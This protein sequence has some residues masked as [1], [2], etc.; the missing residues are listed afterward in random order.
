MI[1]WTISCV[2]LYSIF[3]LAFSSFRACICFSRSS[4]LERSLSKTAREI[5]ATCKLSTQYHDIRVSSFQRRSRTRTF[6]DGIISGFDTQIYD[7]CTK[8]QFLPI[9]VVSKPADL[10]VLLCSLLGA[11]RHLLEHVLIDT[12]GGAHCHVVL[13]IREAAD[14]GASAITNSVPW[15]LEV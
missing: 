12:N 8:Q 3:K 5:A 15:A 13:H 2:F 10:L 7:I 4:P 11:P 9:K 14:V 6:C 1:F